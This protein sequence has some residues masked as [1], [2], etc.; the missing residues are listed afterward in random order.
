VSDLYAVILAGGKGERF[1]PLSTPEEPKPF[2]K[3]FSERSLLQQTFDRARK[4]VSAERILL[5]VGKQHERISREQLPELPETQ[6]LL[7]PSGRDTAAAIGFA[8]FALPSD[9]LMLLL[10]AD[11]LIPDNE[12]FAKDMGAATEFVQDHGGPCTFGIKPDRLETGYG[13][14]KTAGR[15]LASRI[16]PVERFVEKPDRLEAEKYLLNDSFYWNSGIFL[17]KVSRIQERLAE[18][19]PELWAALQQLAPSKPGFA[20]RYES[21]PKIS[22]DY[23]VMQKEK[24]VVMLPASFRWDDVGSWNSLPRIL[25]SN[26]DGNLIW[27]NHTGLETSNCILYAESHTMVTAGIQDL[28]IVQRGKYILICHKN[29]ANRLKELLAKLSR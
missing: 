29:L 12:A 16:Y 11:H 2:L 3:F 28:V 5:V 27:G 8:S 6:L 26:S 10:P 13:Y 21:L 24:D 15:Q 7:E 22:I 19:L 9:A 18:H 25:E 14:I 23:G 4:L 20:E 17:W 1:W